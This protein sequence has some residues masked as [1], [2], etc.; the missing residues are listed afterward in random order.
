MEKVT[1]RCASLDDCSDTD[2]ISL[3]NSFIYLHFV[4]MKK[5]FHFLLRF[6]EF[7]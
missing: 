2:L 7:I 5:N 3:L 6:A 4:K 1:L